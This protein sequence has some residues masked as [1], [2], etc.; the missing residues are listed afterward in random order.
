MSGAEAAMHGHVH[1]VSSPTVDHYS[2][3]QLAKTSAAQQA[4]AT[5]RKL[6]R[7]AEEMGSGELGSDA[8][9]MLGRWKG[10]AGGTRDDGAKDGE[11]SREAGIGD[12][13]SVSSGY[14]SSASVSGRTGGAISFWA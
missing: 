12:F 11:S 10:E 9:E 5:R 1:G 7:A 13:S 8:V 3:A 6:L 2:A 14:V 4:A